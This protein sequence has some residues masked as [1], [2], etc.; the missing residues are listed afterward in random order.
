VAPA[1][2]AQPA[3]LVLRRSATRTSPVE[4]HATR[5]GRDLV[6]LDVKADAYYCLAEAA[7]SVRVVDHAGSLEVADPDLA[8]ALSE[9]GIAAPGGL[10]TG[11]GEGPPKATRDLAGLGPGVPYWRDGVNFAIAIATLAPNYY[12]RSF[13]HLVKN[14]RDAHH[15]D[16]APEP[17][18]RLVET[19]ARFQRWSP[20]APYQGVCLYR[21]YALLRWLRREGLRAHWVF[22][23]QTW[24][25]AAHCWLQVGEVALDD[26]ADTTLSYSPILVV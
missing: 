14:A 18:A 7:P 1:Q 8:R 25:F 24:P 22:G 6:L 10:L 17:S 9:A 2:P 15:I 13:H 16:V 12:G 11:P 21:S 26:L 23:V 4:L 20:W 5:H 19:V 3:P